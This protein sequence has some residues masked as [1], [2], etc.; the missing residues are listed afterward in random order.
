MILNGCASS[1][2]MF[3]TNS[4]AKENDL[5]VRCD[6][7]ARTGSNRKT[8]VCRTIEQI[9]ED[10]KVAQRDLDKIQRKTGMTKND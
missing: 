5:G 10:Q 2:D 6:V 7:M 9:K 4:T 3:K 8:K 1:Q